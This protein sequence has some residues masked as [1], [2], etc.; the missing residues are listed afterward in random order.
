VKVEF[1]GDDRDGCA[2]DGRTDKAGFVVLIA[3]TEL[4]RIGSLEGSA[5]PSLALLGNLPIEICRGVPEGGAAT[6]ALAAFLT[7]F[8]TPRP[9]SSSPKA[10]VVAE[11]VDNLEFTLDL[12]AFVSNFFLP[13]TNTSQRSPSSSSSL[14]CWS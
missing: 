2:V 14:A 9:P 13:L 11:T 3:T 6:D 10:T 12:E 5:S 8:V 1:V 4:L 7:E